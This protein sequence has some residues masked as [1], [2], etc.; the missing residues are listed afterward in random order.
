MLEY[1]WIGTSEFLE[2]E[3]ETEKDHEGDNIVSSMFAD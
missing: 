3:N 1:A 2:V